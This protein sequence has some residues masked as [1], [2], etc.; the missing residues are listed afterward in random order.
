MIQSNEDFFLFFLGK[1]ILSTL[2]PNFKFSDLCYK[3]WWVEI[4][5]RENVWK[6]KMAI[7]SKRMW[8]SFKL[9]H[10]NNKL[11]KKFFLVAPSSVW[12]GGKKKLSFF[13]HNVIGG[14]DGALISIFPTNNSFILSGNPINFEI[15]TQRWK[16]K[17]K[18]IFCLSE[19][20]NLFHNFSLGQSLNIPVYIPCD[21]LF[22]CCKIGL[23]KTDTM[24]ISSILN[25]CI[26]DE[27]PA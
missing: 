17:I 4:N 10:T 9:L 14:S 19:Q 7:W 18:K 6:S 22:G 1:N 3:H 20:K 12:L 21:T 27:C 8:F 24:Y 16:D 11:A 25:N 5:Q 15:R 2:E 13:F 23:S 26:I